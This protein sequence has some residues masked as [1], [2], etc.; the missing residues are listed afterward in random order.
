MMVDQL[1]Y[2]LLMMKNMSLILGK[3]FLVDKF[4]FN[5]YIKPIKRLTFYFFKYAKLDLMI[6]KHS[7][8]NRTCKA[9]AGKIFWGG[10]GLSISMLY[11]VIKYEI[12]TN[13]SYFKK[14]NFRGG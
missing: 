11:Y 13:Q 14:K 1:N 12:L 3:T 10:K 5:L 4:S 9:V 8:Y 6:V 7:L 2:F